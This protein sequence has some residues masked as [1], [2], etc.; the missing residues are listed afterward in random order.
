MVSNFAHDATGR[1]L[2]YKQDRYF[3]L[4]FLCYFFMWFLVLLIIAW[5]QILDSNKCMYVCVMH[6]VILS[7]PFQHLKVKYAD[8][9]YSNVASCSINFVVHQTFT[10][11]TF[12][13]WLTSKIRQSYSKLEGDFL[14]VGCPSCCR[15]SRIKA[16]RGCC[17]VTN[18]VWRW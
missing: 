10:N 3:H 7:F 11:T 9:I 8:H 15:T 4:L 16:L 18:K 13:F 2:F 5:I 17:K 14:Q 12:D 6:L 1:L